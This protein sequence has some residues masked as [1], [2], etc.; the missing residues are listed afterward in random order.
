[1][2]HQAR[3]LGAMTLADSINW[4]AGDFHQWV[5]PVGPEC[6]GCECCSAVLCTTAAARGLPCATVGASADFNLDRCPCAALAAARRLL[7]H[8][9]ALDPSHPD[10]EGR[11]DRATTE[12]RY[13][14]RNGIVVSA[15]QHLAVAGVPVGVTRDP[16][17]PH[18][19]VLTIELPG[20]GQVTW[21]LPDSPDDYHL[22]PAALWDGHD[23]CTKYARLAAWLD[24]E[25]VTS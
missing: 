11:W 17:D 12:Q 19:I 14:Y 21:H 16:S 2:S 9:P 6:P 5:R 8:V 10:N 13:G 23:V 20:V 15:A 4:N 25:K 18:P 7:A 22:P 1:M 3:S 24:V